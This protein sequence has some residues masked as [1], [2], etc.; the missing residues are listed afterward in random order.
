MI[1][2]V[3]GKAFVKYGILFVRHRFS[4]Q[5]RIGTGLAAVAAGIAVYLAT[6]NVPE[7]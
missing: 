7:G 2:R 3:I 5:I 1:Y 4:A 6:R